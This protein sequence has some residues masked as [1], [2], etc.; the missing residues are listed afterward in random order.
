M[1]K[2][3][4]K[5][6]RGPYEVTINLEYPTTERLDIPAEWI[7]DVC[8]KC[9]MPMLIDE[10]NNNIHH[11]QPFCVWWKKVWVDKKRM[12]RI[13]EGRKHDKKLIE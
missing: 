8:G 4:P 11:R 12:A 7:K 13:V 9:G 5:I 2:P 3:L 1:D 6:V 10:Q